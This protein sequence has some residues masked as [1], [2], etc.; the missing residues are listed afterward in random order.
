G[1]E[2]PLQLDGA[3]VRVTRGLR[4]PN[5][6]CNWTEPAC[7]LLGAWGPRTPSATGRSRRAG[8]SW[9]EGPER[10]LQL[11][12]AG[13]RATRGLGAPNALC[14]WTEPACGLLV[15]WGP[16]TPPETGRSRLAVY[17]GPGAPNALLNL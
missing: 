9:P 12:G 3:G 5:T 15:A 2:R 10:P 14:N 11:D 6:L 7:G 1:P 8:Y 17:C 4:A 13:V 16:G